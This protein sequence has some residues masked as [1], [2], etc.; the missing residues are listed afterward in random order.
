M[1]NNN[2]SSVDNSFFIVGLLDFI[3]LFGELHVLVGT[4]L[5]AHNQHKIKSEITDFI[6]NDHKYFV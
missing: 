1:N 5:P 3:D 4:T 6:N 2:A